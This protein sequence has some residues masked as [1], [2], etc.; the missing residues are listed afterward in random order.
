MTAG[1]RYVSTVDIRAALLR[2]PYRDHAD[3][4]PSWRWDG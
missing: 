3:D 4:H 1:E 2:C